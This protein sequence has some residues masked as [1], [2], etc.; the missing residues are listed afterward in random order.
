MRYVI[1]PLICTLEKGETGVL[2]AIT[3]SYGS[4][5]RRSGTRM[6]IF[7]DGGIAG[8]IGGGVLEA[9]CLQAAQNLFLDSTKYVELQFDLSAE[10]AAGLGM[11]CGGAVNILLQKVTPE[12]LSLF[13]LLKSEYKKNLSPVL[14][15]SLPVNGNEPFFTLIGME[16]NNTVDEGLQLKI[17]AKS[18]RTPYNISHKGRMYFVEPMA[19]RGTVHIIGA[20]HVG[21]STAHLAASVGFEVVVMDDRT[22]FAD[23]TRFPD[24]VEVRVL[25]NFADCFGDGLT[26]DDYVVIVTRGHIHDKEVLGQALQTSAGYVGMI[27]SSKKRKSTYQTLLNEGFTE[28]DLQRVYC[29]IG[30]SIGAESPQEIGFSIVA[31]LIKAR[32]FCI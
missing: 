7:Q 20:G 31:E 4:V 2:A 18:R 21:L 9:A 5:P 22:E 25:G 32:A 30:L 13:R 10:D 11:V 27:G 16:G 14:I 15:T 1:D 3:V 17:T 6:L 8:T 29:P 23:A 24:S 26:V 28:L 19:H 12:S